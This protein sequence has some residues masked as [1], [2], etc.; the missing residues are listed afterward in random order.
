M[1]RDPA[2]WLKRNWITVYFG[3]VF[4]MLC[5]YAIN[6][7]LS[8]KNESEKLVAMQASVQKYNAYYLSQKESLNTRIAKL[9]AYRNDATW[10]NDE[11]LRLRI[12]EIDELLKAFSNL[13]ISSNTGDQSNDYFTQQMNRVF[14]IEER[15]YLSLVRAR[16]NFNRLFA[17][18]QLLRD[19][20]VQIYAQLQENINKQQKIPGYW[21]KKFVPSTISH[22]LKD[23]YSRIYADNQS[24][25]EAVKTNSVELEKERAK[26]VALQG[27]NQQF[28]LNEAEVQNVLAPLYTKI[29]DGRQLINTHW[30]T[31][32]FRPAF[33]SVPLFVVVLLG[34]AVM[35]LIGQFS[36]QFVYPRI[37]PIISNPHNAQ[38]LMVAFIV[39]CCLF[40]LAIG[41]VKWYE[42]TEKAKSI[43][44]LQATI[45]KMQLKEEQIIAKRTEEFK[46]KILELQG[47]DGVKKFTKQ[48]LGLKIQ[49]KS[50][51]NKDEH[52]KIVEEKFS[53][54]IIKPAQ[55]KSM[56]RDI[57][58]SL[59]DIESLENELFVTL[60]KA[61]VIQPAVG[62]MEGVVQPLLSD[63]DTIKKLDDVTIGGSRVVIATTA[64]TLPFS[65]I[66]GGV[67]EWLLNNYVEAQIEKQVNDTIGTI[68]EKSSAQLNEKLTEYVR[69]RNKQL[70]KDFEGQL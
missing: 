7:Y 51:A 4:T 59:Y 47:S 17:N 16:Y 55:L 23:E 56:Q 2:N 30:A 28:I 6:E 11:A 21:L 9:V 10:Q 64:V 65:L 22:D 34:F 50:L 53:E 37:D 31:Q 40:L 38:K 63:E 52:K 66:L 46:H 49:W 39:L 19:K 20:H 45:N 43:S 14:L 44:A 5:F 18:G 35:G 58:F 32:L 62:A 1:E 29:H 68:A 57:D 67:T 60:Q 27:M 26:I 42:L 25:A 3:I 12:V 54:F 70:L 24:A 33:G 48:M 41:A 15:K 13:P 69:V 8:V 61:P 36:F